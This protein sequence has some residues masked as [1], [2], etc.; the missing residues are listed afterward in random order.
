MFNQKKEILFQKINL[1][2]RM[3]EIQIENSLINFRNLINIITIMIKDKFPKMCKLKLFQNLK[4]LKFYYLQKKKILNINLFKI[5]KL[6]SKFHK[7][8]KNKINSFSVCKDKTM[9]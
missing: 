2:I 7:D 6:K 8:K 5:I 1:K 3:L 9:V 4:I